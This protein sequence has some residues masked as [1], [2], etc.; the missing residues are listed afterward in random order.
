MRRLWEE[1]VQVVSS[2]ILEQIHPSACLNVNDARREEIQ[3]SYEES[4]DMWSYAKI[5]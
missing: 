4:K 2:T 5:W 1:A 3:K